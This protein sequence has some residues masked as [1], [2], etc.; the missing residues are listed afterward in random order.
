[1][2]SKIKKIIKIKK[3]LNEAKSYL[4]IERY[5]E[6]IECFTEAIELNPE[7]AMVYTYRA[8][9][10]KKKQEYGKAISDF[11]K[12]IE[13]DSQNAAVYTNSIG[14]IY[15]TAWTKVIV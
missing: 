5:N 2:F 8:S 9:V 1:M 13:L 14:V 6:A 10:Y 4:D 15:L 11:N 7:D 12:A 3:L